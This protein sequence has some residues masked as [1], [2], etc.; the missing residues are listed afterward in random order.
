MHPLVLALDLFEESR[1]FIVVLSHQVEEV[2]TFNQHVEELALATFREVVFPLLILQL[3]EV[4]GVQILEQ[5]GSEGVAFLDLRSQDVFKFS[6]LR[7]CEHTCVEFAPVG[8]LNLRH[9]FPWVVNHRRL[10][11]FIIQ[12][13]HCQWCLG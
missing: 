5:A 3:L 12:R 1:D 11:P 4:L 7:L 9:I 8:W 6:Q 13:Q 2:V 10:I